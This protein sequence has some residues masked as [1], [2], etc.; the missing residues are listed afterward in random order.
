MLAGHR[1]Q[2]L[3]I[4]AHSESQARSCEAPA[5]LQSCRGGATRTCLLHTSLHQATAGQ[6]TSAPLQ[7]LA[8]LW[9]LPSD[10][11]SVS[12]STVCPR[13]CLV[14]E[15]RSAELGSVGMWGSEHAYVYVYVSHV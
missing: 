3:G 5:A 6:H 11:G 14:R 13:S 7:G 10:T 8:L 2:T 9:W 15:K 4:P 12:S 1:A